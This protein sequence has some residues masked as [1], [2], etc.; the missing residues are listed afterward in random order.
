MTAESPG[1]MLDAWRWLRGLVLLLA[2]VV[3]ICPAVSQMMS[4]ESSRSDERNESY[5]H[6]TMADVHF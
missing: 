2:V 1:W 6:H 3:M 4:A 5:S